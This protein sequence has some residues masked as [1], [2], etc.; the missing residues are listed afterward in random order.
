MK[1]HINTQEVTGSS[2][3]PP[4]P[5]SVHI[6]EELPLR[7]LLEILL[8]ADGRRKLRLRT[9]SNNELLTLYD[10]DLVLR[11]HN[12]RTLESNR[13]LYRRSL[14]SIHR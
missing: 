1:H 14:T 6:T 12:A 4:I 5:A 11:V 9:K 7:E 8:G 2:P 13:N 3:V 10:S